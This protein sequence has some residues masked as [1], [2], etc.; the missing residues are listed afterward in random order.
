ML[1]SFGTQ[2]E[3]LPALGRLREPDEDDANAGVLRFGDTLPQVFV[4]TEKVRR[5][6]DT[7]ARLGDFSE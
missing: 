1:V 5:Y 6:L 4:S 2:R 7:G 3:G